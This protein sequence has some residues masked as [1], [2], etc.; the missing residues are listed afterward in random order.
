MDWRMEVYFA[1]WQFAWHYMKYYYF[2]RGD[3]KSLDWNTISAEC[4][5]Q[6]ILPSSR[7]E[8]A[9]EEEWNKVCRIE[10]G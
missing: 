5:I 1:Q 6:Y 3:R 7:Q 8:L 10:W 9:E 4:W 2:L